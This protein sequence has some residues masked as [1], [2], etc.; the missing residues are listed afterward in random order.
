MIAK[1][2]RNQ[3]RVCFVCGWLAQMEDDQME[4]KWM[5]RGK[6][7]WMRVRMP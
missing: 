2:N 5:D 6:Q 1:L 7:K 4:A 3:L